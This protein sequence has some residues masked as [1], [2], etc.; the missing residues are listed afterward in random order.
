V[1]ELNFISIH[2]KYILFNLAGVILGVILD[3]ILD[4]NI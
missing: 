2:L 4:V 3:A 1:E